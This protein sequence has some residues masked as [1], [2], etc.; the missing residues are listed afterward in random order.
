MANTN[1]ITGQ[2]YGAKEGTEKFYHEQAH[3]LF[4]DNCR[5]GNLMR[6]IQDLSFRYLVMVIALE[7]LM[8]NPLFQSFIVILFCSS[9]T[10][11][12]Y[13]EVWCWNYARKT[14]REKERA[15]RRKKIY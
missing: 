10:S 5:D 14:L 4:E 8:H 3:L 15:K 11:E 2:I 12:I 9:V 1:L 7:V 13:E 6:S